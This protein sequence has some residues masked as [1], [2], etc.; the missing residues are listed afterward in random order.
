MRITKLVAA[1]IG[2]PM[3][4]G[5]FALAVGGG[6]A[7]AVPDDDGWISTGPVRMRTDAA[8]L[9]GED[10]EIDFGEHFTDGRTFIGW[11]A[12]PARLEIDS[13]N[14]KSVFVG[15]ATQDDA[16]AYLQGV[17]VDRVV[18]FDNHP[19]LRHVDGAFVASPP[20]S[21]DIWVASSVDGRLD[22]DVAGGDWAIVALNADGSPGVD[23]SLNGSARVPFLGA[24][25]IVLIAVG[26]VG[27]TTGGFL[28]Y[29]GVRQVRV[30]VA[31]VTPPVPESPITG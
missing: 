8:A 4:I 17:A 28:I 10:I 20:A 13:R 22:W 11:E 6:I 9:V 18:S 21:H 19:E 14:D 16:R 12:I 2:V 1:V 26:L 3:I 29:Y 27:M 24:I 15:I 31:P 23:V 7:L 5:S 25:G 30:P